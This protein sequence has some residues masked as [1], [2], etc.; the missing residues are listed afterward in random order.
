MALHDYKKQYLNQLSQ[1]GSFANGWSAFRYQIEAVV[2]R[3]PSGQQ[4]FNLGDQLR[5]IFRGNA[6]PGRA[7]SQLSA[8]G[9]CWE[10]LIVWYLNLVFWGTSVSVAR[11]TR[12]AVPV[13]LREA[14]TVTILNNQ[15]NTE[16]DVLLFNTPDEAGFTGSTTEELNNHLSPRL[17]EVEL[18]NLQCKTNWN[19]NAQIPMLWD[20]I[21]NSQ[22]RPSS[23]GV[24][25]HG[26]S[27]E[28]FARFRY[29]FATVPSQNSSFTPR[30]MPALR[31][32]GLSGGNYWGRPTQA[33]VARSISELPGFTFSGVFAGGV[34]NHI[35]H[36]LQAGNLRFD[37][38]LNLNW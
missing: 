21:Y 5:D 30:S 26:V 27:P 36:Q 29:A 37:D 14:L 22:R 28:S 9:A 34:A 20:I 32:Q 17:H 12:T 8:A 25:I 19:D 1:V 6:F 23:V 16:S 18:V 31:V 13:R 11:T 2:G 38:F 10:A 3:N 15:T 33:G 4:I 35:D 7:Q 24:G